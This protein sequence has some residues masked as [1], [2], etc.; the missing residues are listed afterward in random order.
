VFDDDQQIINFL[1]MEDTFQGA[2]IDKN[3]HD[4]NIQNF[5]VIYDPHSIESSSYLVKNFPKYVIKLEIFYDLH[6]KSKG[7]VN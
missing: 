6:D 1:H 7:V 3:T 2:V 4:E 5:S